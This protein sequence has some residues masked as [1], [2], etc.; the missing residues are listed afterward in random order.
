MNNNGNYSVGTVICPLEDGEDGVIVTLP[1]MDNEYYIDEVLRKVML[2]ASGDD[3]PE[4]SNIALGID[5]WNRWP[6]DLR[7]A[8]MLNMVDYCYAEGFPPEHQLVV[9]LNYLEN[10][11]LSAGIKAD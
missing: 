5:T 3:E 7:E 10:L 1:C 11:G 8:T 2:D 6:Y 9:L 4:L